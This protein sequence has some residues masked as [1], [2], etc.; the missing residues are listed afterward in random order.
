[1]ENI[2]LKQETEIEKEK[3]GTSTTRRKNLSSS[4]QRI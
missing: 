2:N 4:R 1:M 3:K